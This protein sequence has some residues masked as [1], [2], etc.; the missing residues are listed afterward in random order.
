MADV[1]GSTCLVF[2]YFDRDSKFDCDV[3]TL[4]ICIIYVQSSSLEKLNDK[5]KK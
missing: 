3:L 2:I 1:P 4:L 5:L